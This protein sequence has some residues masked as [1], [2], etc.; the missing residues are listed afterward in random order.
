MGIAHILLNRHRQD[1]ATLVLIGKPWDGRP[2]I[3]LAN[4]ARTIYI[5]FLLVCL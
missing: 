5:L 1:M 2:T 3:E 4:M